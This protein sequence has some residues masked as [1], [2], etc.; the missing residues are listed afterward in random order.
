MVFGLL[1]LWCSGLQTRLD[2]TVP[3]LGPRLV[4]QKNPPAQKLLLNLYTNDS[5]RYR[6]VRQ[7]FP[8]TFWTFLVA[9]MSFS[10][11]EVMETYWR[12]L[13]ERKGQCG[14]NPIPAGRAA[15]A[16]HSTALGA[17]GAGGEGRQHSSSAIKDAAGHQRPFRAE[18][19]MT[20]IPPPL[21]PL[22]AT[23]AL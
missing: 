12:G 4:I 22:L 6:Q 13:E 23:S 11:V 17:L 18:V 15:A 16:L 14:S 1:L 9:V 21:R 10:E 2:S 8:Q 20:A 7:T 19:L 5:N 3:F